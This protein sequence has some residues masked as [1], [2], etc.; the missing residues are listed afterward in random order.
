[1]LYVNFPCRIHALSAGA[2]GEYGPRGIISHHNAQIGF[3][4]ML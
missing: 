4:V 2:I 1:M 3:V